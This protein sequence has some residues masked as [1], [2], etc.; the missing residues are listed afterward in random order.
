MIKP[1]S[2]LVVSVAVSI[3]GL[4][5]LVRQFIFDPSHAYINRPGY[6]SYVQVDDILPNV[7]GNHTISFNKI[8]ARGQLP[9]LG[10]APVI[11]IFGGSTVVDWVLDDSESW[12]GQLQSNLSR[13]WE[14]VA[15]LNY[16]KLGANA[17]HHL[18]QIPELDP[19]SPKMDIMV[20]L[21]GL[22]DFLYDLRIHHRVE[23]PDGWWRKQAIGTEQYEEGKIAIV[24]VFKRVMHRY[25]S[26]AGQQLAVSNFGDYIKSFWEVRAKVPPE[27]WVHDLPDLTP[28][29][30]T[31]QDTISKLNAAADRLGARLVLVTQPYLWSQQMTE[32]AERQLIG[33]F[34]GHDHLDP[35]AFW[36]TPDALE[37]GLKAYN[38]ILRS[39]CTQTG[40]DC[41]DA[42]SVM[43]GDEYNFYDDFHFSERGAERLGKLVSSYLLEEG[44]TCSPQ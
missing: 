35:E 29:L 25:F 2:L 22:N 1:V 30:A 36:Y 24:A 32:S 23:T 40:Y 18:I 26:A 34:I 7:S 44:K 4:E 15:T 37:R 39:T 9:G 42:A 5:L 17:R 20:V 14:N 28:H 38:D 19:Y 10:D 11:G 21:M 33:G 13:C 3:V 27:K 31:Y 16:G 12:T 6:T 41:V 43:N 8:G